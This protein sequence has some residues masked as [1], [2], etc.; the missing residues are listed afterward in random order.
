MVVTRVEAQA[1]VASFRYPHFLV[2]RQPTYEMPPPAT[3]YGHLCS[4][5]GEW[6][7]PNDALLGLR[8]T[9]EAQ[10]FDLEHQVIVSGGTGRLGGSSLPETLRGTVQPVN[11][12][13]LFDCRLTLYVAGDWVPAFRSPRYAAV[14]GRSQDLASYTRV[15]RVELQRSPH[16]YYEHTLLPWS[17]RGAV[18]RG[19]T[20]T[21]ARWIDYEHGRQP[22]FDRFLIVKE[23][24]LTNSADHWM[25]IPGGPDAHWVDPEAPT[26]QGLGRGVW[27]HP[28]VVANG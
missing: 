11:R 21:M 19:R 6:V 26:L 4:A 5:V 8:F 28:L 2:G 17:L 27:L 10:A 13:F 25:H 3:L 16:A 24:V 7:D 14:L 1:P 9:Y 12:G 15:D 20:E 18:L 22:H 23:P